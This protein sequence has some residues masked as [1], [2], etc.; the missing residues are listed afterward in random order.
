MCCFTHFGWHALTVGKGVA[1]RHVPTTPFQ[2]VPPR[3]KKV[4]RR[5]QEL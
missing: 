2:G 1:K 4:A 5:K 3:R